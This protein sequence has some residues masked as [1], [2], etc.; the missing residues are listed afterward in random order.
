MVAKK[1]VVKRKVA[2]KKKVA[3]R[4]VVAKKP[5]SPVELTTAHKKAIT[6]H[7][8][9][10]AA[11]NKALDAIKNSADKVKAAKTVA[12]KNNAQQRHIAW[13]EKVASAKSALSAAVAEVKSHEASAREFATMVMAKE[14]AI[15]AFV[16]KWEKDY[17]KKLAARKRSAKARA[18]AAAQRRKSQANKS[19]AQ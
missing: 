11:L 4:K 15:V 18:K 1:K 17:M 7:D 8:R 6:T 12:A 16:T 14:K 9:V 5:V 3:K 13:K 10:S 19:E 2:A